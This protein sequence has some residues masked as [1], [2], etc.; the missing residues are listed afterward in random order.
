MLKIHLKSLHWKFDRRNHKF[1]YLILLMAQNNSSFFFYIVSKL[2]VVRDLGIMTKVIGTALL[3][4][5]LIKYASLII[6][7]V[8]LLGESSHIILDILY[9][10]V[11]QCT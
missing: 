2:T 11:P 10:K 6:S 3:I 5:Y 8:C 9:H 4:F 7:K 1:G